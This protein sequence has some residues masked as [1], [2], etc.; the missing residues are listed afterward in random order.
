M[1]LIEYGKEKDNNSKHNINKSIKKTRKNTFYKNYK[2]ILKS[3]KIV[4]SLP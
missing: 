3:I 2:R 1:H 4:I